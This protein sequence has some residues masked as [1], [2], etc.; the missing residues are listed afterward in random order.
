MPLGKSKSCVLSYTIF[1]HHM[2]LAEVSLMALAHHVDLGI[3][4]FNASDERTQ[5]LWIQYDNGVRT[6]I[7]LLV[8]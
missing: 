8:G 5:R 7:R 3:N 2:E 1:D 4:G 6:S